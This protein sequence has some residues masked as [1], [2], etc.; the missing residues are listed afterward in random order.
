MASSMGQHGGVDPGTLASHD[1]VVDD[2]ACFVRSIGVTEPCE[3][4]SAMVPHLTMQFDGTETAGRVAHRLH[5]LD[6]D[7]PALDIDVNG[8][9]VTVTYHLTSTNEGIRI[10]S[11]VHPVASLGVR[12]VP[13]D[14]HRNGTHHPLGTFI[15]A[16][17]STSSI[18]NEPFDYLD[19][20]PALLVALGVEPLDHHRSTEV[21]I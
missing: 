12:A 21:T 17:S 14:A 9:S 8:A 5:D 7:G 18:P 4:R 20:A 15:V 13:V 6:F 19:V 10:G 16:N 3:L 2:P 11:V 1:L